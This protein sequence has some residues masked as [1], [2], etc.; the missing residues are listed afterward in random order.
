MFKILTQ[1][2]KGTQ[3]GVKNSLEGV[4]DISSVTV[5]AVKR[6]TV[7]TFNPHYSSG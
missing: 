2:V 5:N 6:V 1:I 4:A 3:A 7:D